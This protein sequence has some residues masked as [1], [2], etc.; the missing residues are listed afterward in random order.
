MG[1]EH[2]LRQVAMKRQEHDGITLPQETRRRIT[3]YHGR[4]VLEQTPRQSTWPAPAGKDGVV[5]EMDGGMVPVVLATPDA[6]DRRQGKTL[7]WQ[8]LKL[9]IARGLDH[10]ERFYGGRF[11]GDVTE[12]GQQL[13]HCACLAGFGRATAIH[14]V[15]DGARWIADQVERQCGRQGPYLV[16]F[17][18]LSEYLA[19]AAPRCAD[20]AKAWLKQPQVALKANRS[21][22]VLPALLPPIEPPLEP[23]DKAPVR[24]AYR[25]LRNRQDQLDYAG[26]IATGRPIGSGE[27]ESAHR[28]V[29]QA[30]LKKPGAWWKPENVDPMVAWRLARLNGRWDKYRQGAMAAGA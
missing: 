11:L 6:A 5:V 23:D 10:T 27:V 22:G 21:S 20:D 29:V 9:C 28:F 2:A 16:D 19:D 14:R 3:Q 15:G 24:K 1:A 8:A 17:Y 25:Y 26:A 4:C 13:Y 7:K 12:A 18:H 30:R